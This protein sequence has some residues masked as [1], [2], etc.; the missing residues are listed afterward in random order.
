M[1]LL[2]EKILY[3][4]EGL[5]CP[6]CLEGERSAPPEDCGGKSGYEAFLKAIS[7]ITHPDH[8]WM[9]EWA[10]GQFDPEKFD[11]DNINKLLA[12]VR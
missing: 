3:P 6:I 5:E 4:E 7:D 10:G 11:R 9:L 12:E 1:A 2:V 8:D